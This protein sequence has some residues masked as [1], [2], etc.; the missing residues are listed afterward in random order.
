MYNMYIVYQ[1]QQKKYR[2]RET[3]NLLTDADSSAN[4]FFVFAAAAAAVK[5]TFVQ[6]N[7]WEGP[8]SRPHFTLL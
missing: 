3:K 6:K 1:K 7:I 2:I 5:E 8:G 4:I